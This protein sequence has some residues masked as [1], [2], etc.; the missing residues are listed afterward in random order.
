MDLR[1]AAVIAASTFLLGITRVSWIAYKKNAS[2][3]TLA[4]FAFA[5]ARVGEVFILWTILI[6]GALVA[7]WAGVWSGF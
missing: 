3:A 4:T 2:P 5:K 6:A 1:S 7:K